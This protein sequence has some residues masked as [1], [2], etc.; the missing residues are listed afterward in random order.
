MPVA[1][2]IKT[3]G[4]EYGREYQ[5]ENRNFSQGQHRL[6]KTAAVDRAT[7]LAGSGLTVEAARVGMGKAGSMQ[8]SIADRAQHGHHSCTALTFNHECLSHQNYPIVPY[9]RG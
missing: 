4:D 1:K 7:N 8:C 2:Q 6:V 5:L 3:M 9:C